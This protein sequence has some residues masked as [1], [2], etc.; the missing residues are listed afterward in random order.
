MFLSKLSVR[1]FFNGG[2]IEASNGPRILL[3]RRSSSLFSDKKIIY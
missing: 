3:P 1:K 2:K